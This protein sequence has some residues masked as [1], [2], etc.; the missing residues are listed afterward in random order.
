MHC[1]TMEV[2]DSPTPRAS[3][4]ENDAGHRRLVRALVVACIVGGTWLVAQDVGLSALDG[5]LR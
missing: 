1:T 2:E 5:L 4:P 3:T